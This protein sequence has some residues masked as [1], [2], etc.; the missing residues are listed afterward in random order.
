MKKMFGLVLTLGAVV[1]VG[2]TAKANEIIGKNL[3]E[4]PY[5]KTAVTR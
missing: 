3:S 1:L 4:V 5:E 2:C